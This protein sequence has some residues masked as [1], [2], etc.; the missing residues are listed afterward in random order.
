MNIQTTEAL[1]DEVLQDATGIVL[2]EPR[3]KGLEEAMT[4]L[5]AGA[6]LSS[7]WLSTVESWLKQSSSIAALTLRLNELAE[8]YHSLDEH[9]TARR[10]CHAAHTL[11]QIV[12]GLE[13]ENTM[14]ISA[15]LAK[16][17]ALTEA[18]IKSKPELPKLRNFS[19]R[20]SK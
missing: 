6:E 2:F 14:L 7:S 4:G 13:H 15:N 1:W 17:E 10:I 12:V 16:L 11:S 18:A 19:G 3:L 8:K 5:A 20:K 9:G